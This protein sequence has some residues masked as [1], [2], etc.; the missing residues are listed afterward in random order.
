M[1]S[2]VT[3]THWPHKPDVSGSTPDSAIKGT[4]SKAMVKDEAGNFV[5]CGRIHKA[6]LV[7]TLSIFSFPFH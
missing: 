3:V 6:C 7:N 2:C 1:Q 5:R 4:N